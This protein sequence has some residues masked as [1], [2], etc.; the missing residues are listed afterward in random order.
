MK[1]TK[2]RALQIKD[3]PPNLRLVCWFMDASLRARSAIK[4]LAFDTS[5]LVG[6]SAG[7]VRSSTTPRQSDRA[8]SRT[9][10]AL[11][12]ANSPCGGIVSSLHAVVLTL[13]EPRAV[14]L[15]G[16][17]LGR[18]VT[19]LATV[20]QFCDNV[21]GS[22]KLAKG[23]QAFWSVWEAQCGSNLHGKFAH[24]LAITIRVLSVSFGEGFI[25]GN[26]VSA[27]S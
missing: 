9:R 27:Y 23:L 13:R 4:R 2:Q 15:C 22:Y 19:C 21:R 16:T 18:I 3:C 12:R 7:F 11:V 8:K 25:A 26:N 10:N 5:D 6:P 20:S 24:Y 17:V 14:I 1:V